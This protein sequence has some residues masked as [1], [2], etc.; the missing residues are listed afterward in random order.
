[1]SVRGGITLRDE[2]GVRLTNTE[3][4]RE[5]DVIPFPFEYIIRRHFSLWIAPR[6]SL[7]LFD[8]KSFVTHLLKNNWT[9]LILSPI[10]YDLWF[11]EYVFQKRVTYLLIISV[12]ELFKPQNEHVNVKL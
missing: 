5:S 9:R 3:S 1:M 6:E 12:F 7:K 10:N 4:T 11:P 2:Q 8:Q